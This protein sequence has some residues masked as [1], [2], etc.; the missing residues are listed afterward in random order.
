ML[1]HHPVCL[2]CFLSTGYYYKDK[3]YI[4]FKNYL[5]QKYVFI[6]IKMK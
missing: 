2:L 6:E 3:S 1:L 5:L 4:I